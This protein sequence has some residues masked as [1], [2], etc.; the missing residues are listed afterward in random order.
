M[1]ELCSYWHLVCIFHRVGVY[2]KCMGVLLFPV[3]TT[4][5]ESRFR[6]IVLLFRPIALKGVL[7]SMSVENALDKIVD[8]KVCTWLSCLPLVKNT[9]D[10]TSQTA[11]DTQHKVTVS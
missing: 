8:E 6:N 1:P 7:F 10:S 11:P 2:V 5:N 9:N 3:S 4:G